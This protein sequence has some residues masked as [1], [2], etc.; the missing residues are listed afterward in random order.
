MDIPFI[1]LVD[2][3]TAILESF[4]IILE[5]EG[6]RVSTAK[7]GFELKALLSKNTPDL[8]LM[9]YNLGKD[10]SEKLTQ[11]LKTNSQTSHVPVIIISADS[12][13]RT[14]ALTMGADDFIEKPTEISLLLS[15]IKRYVTRE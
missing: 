12:M 10:S 14:L 9:D 5:H 8:I 6:Y 13:L 3:D 15:K 4:K 1:L 11:E 7:N 2:D